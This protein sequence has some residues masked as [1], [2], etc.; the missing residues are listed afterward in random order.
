MSMT[1]KFGRMAGL[2]L[3]LVLAAPAWGELSLQSSNGARYVSGGIG[4]GE[5]EEM[6]LI[7]P[8]YNLKVVAAAQGSGAFIADVGLV[9]RD[10]RG[11]TVFETTLD[12]PWLMGHLPPGRYELQATHG[13]AMQKRT[14]TLPAT[15]HRLEYFYWSVPGAETLKS[16]ER[17]EQP[18]PG[19]GT[20]R[21][22]ER[23]EQPPP[24]GTR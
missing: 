16:L 23:Q 17:Q 14:V 6:L 11:E 13:G 12:G 18:A 24:G 19:A 7:L 15:G 4:E 9:V 10:A 21:L 22:L 2:A 1:A 20:L 3:A 8:D 5:R